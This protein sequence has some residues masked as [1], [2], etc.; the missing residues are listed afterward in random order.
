ML[1]SSVPLSLTIMCG[2]PRWP[3]MTV[4]SRAI[5]APEIDLSATSARYSLQKSLIKHRMRATP[6][7]DEAAR[8]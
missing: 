6:A 7:T 5:L 2:L 4:S 8:D 1:V 3:M